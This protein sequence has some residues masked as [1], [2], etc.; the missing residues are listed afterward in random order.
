MS[1]ARSSPAVGSGTAHS[2]TRSGATPGALPAPG[3]TDTITPHAD[4]WTRA[5]TD[6]WLHRSAG[7]RQVSTASRSCTAAA[8]NGVRLACAWTVSSSPTSSSS[9]SRATSRVAAPAATPR[10]PVGRQTLG[11][12]TAR[13]SPPPRTTSPHCDCATTTRSPASMSACGSDSSTTSACGE[14]GPARGSGRITSVSQDSSNTAPS[15][16]GTAIA[17]SGPELDGRRRCGAAAASTAP[18]RLTEVDVVRRQ[19]PCL[20]LTRREVPPHGVLT[21]LREQTRRPAHPGDGGAQARSSTTSSLTRAWP[22]AS[23][24]HRRSSSTP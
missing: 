11:S 24:A 22:A 4:S 6:D 16:T 8:S 12:T 10:R 2:A 17:T 19:Q 3:S 13:R 14:L 7:T 9:P 18:Q 20:Q 23:A 21:Q 5:P 1:I 15:G